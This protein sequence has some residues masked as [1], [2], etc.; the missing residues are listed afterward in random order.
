VN[1][2]EHTQRISKIFGKE[3][4][5]PQHTFIRHN[6]HSASARQCII[7]A[8][9]PMIVQAESLE[10]SSSQCERWNEVEAQSASSMLTDK[11]ILRKRDLEFPQHDVTVVKRKECIG[12]SSFYEVKDNSANST[13]DGIP[14]SRDRNFLMKAT[15]AA[16]REQARRAEAEVRMLRRL[17]EHRNIMQFLDSGCS[18]MESSPENHK[19]DDDVLLELQR[20]YCLLFRD[21]PSRNVRD[22]M[23]KHRQKLERRGESS[24]WIDTESALGIFRQM[25]VAVSVLHDGPNTRNDSRGPSTSS[26]VHMDIRPEHFAAFKTSRDISKGC[27]YIVKL[28]GLGCAIED[29]MPLDTLEDRMKAARLI[30][31]N[32]SPKYRAPE[33]IN[34]KLT[35]ELTDSV[36]IWALG[37]CLYGILF[38]KDCFQEDSRLN[39]LKGKYEIPEGHPYSKDV[40]DLLARLLCVDPDKR[41]DIHEVISCI[42][43]LASGKV[44]P[45]KQ[46]KAMCA[47]RATETSPDP[48]FDKVCASWLIT[49]L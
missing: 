40:L 43:A 19:R 18:A 27:K 47:S 16:T 9:Y 11:S 23:G 25:A 32:T 4:V 10:S 5:Q 15:V 35:D 44:L 8:L 30:D 31:S 46:S 17:P 1:A 7:E 42:D 37:C 12:S 33:M 39:I 38:L 24:G 13:N 49:L 36:D 2:E 29:G 20:V 45:P 41:P 21:C 6:T 48:R 34:L 26:I 3:K 14:P 28:V 22:V